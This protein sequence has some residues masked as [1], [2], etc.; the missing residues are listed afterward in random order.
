MNPRTVIPLL[1]MLL[2]GVASGESGKA[3][4]SDATE[5]SSGN[6]ALGALQPVG[7]AEVPSAKMQGW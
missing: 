1:S 6:D 3:A 7:P 5:S 2:V 4:G